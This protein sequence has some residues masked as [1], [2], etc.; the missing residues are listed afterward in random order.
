MLEWRVEKEGAG[1]EGREGGCWGGGERR[2]VP[3]VKGRERRVLG[4]RGSE[5]GCCGGG[6]ERS[7]LG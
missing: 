4:R 1:V 5:E 6:G 3:G 2:R 7:V